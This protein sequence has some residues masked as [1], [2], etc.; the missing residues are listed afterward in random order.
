MSS[1]LK[2]YTD[3]GRWIKW[4]LRKRWAN[5]LTDKAYLSLMYEAR[6]GKKMDWNYPRTFNEKLQWLKLY[7]RNPEYSVMADKYAVRDYISRTIGSEYLIPMIGVWD[8]FEDIDFSKLPDRFVLKCT[9]DSGSVFICKDK[10]EM[11]KEKAKTKINDALKTNYYYH[12]REWP[13]KD[14]KPRVICEEYLS[15]TDSPPEDYKVLCFSGKAKLIEV[16]IDRFKNHCLNMYYA[17]WRKTKTGFL[18]SDK[19]STAE[20][21]KPKQ[22]EAMIQLSEKLAS[23]ISHVRIDWFI[24][25]SKLYFGEI[26]FFESSGFNDYANE[27][28]DYLL[29]SWIELP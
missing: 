17:G 21:E 22:F 23:G 11:D 6:L 18:K 5:H 8:K 19:I 29:G 4:I 20:S 13:Y 24:V 14:I 25:S 12:G 15:E 10:N 26:T 3:K 1:S 16:H 28:D 27:K 9:H 2:K 7:N